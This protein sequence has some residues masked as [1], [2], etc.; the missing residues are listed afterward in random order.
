MTSETPQHPNRPHS[1]A[2]SICTLDPPRERDMEPKL[3]P[4]LPEQPTASEVTTITDV[5]RSEPEDGGG[6]HDEEHD[7]HGH[8]DEENDGFLGS[9]RVANVGADFFEGVALDTTVPFSV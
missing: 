7:S 6:E 8:S 9:L 3:K 5:P 2:S 4:S 1:L